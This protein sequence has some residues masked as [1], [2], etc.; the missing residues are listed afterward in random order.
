MEKYIQEDMVFSGKRIDFP[1]WKVKIISKAA[2]ATP[3]HNQGV[4]GIMLPIAHFDAMFPP[5]LGPPIVRQYRPLHDPQDFATW[6]AIA[7]NA[8]TLQFP[9]AIRLAQFEYATK[10]Y[11]AVQ[12]AANT[13]HSFI[14][15]HLDTTTKVTISHPQTGVA[16]LDLEQLFTAVNNIHGV[17]TSADLGEVDAK[18]CAKYDPAL[19]NMREHIN[20]HANGHLL[21]ESAGSPISIFNKTKTFISS[22]SHQPSY[23]TRIKV[24]MEQTPQVL[25]QTFAALSL[26]MIE[27]EQVAKCFA[28]APTTADVNYAGGAAK[29]KGKGK[30]GGHNSG[31][32]STPAKRATPLPD[33]YCWSH[34]LCKHNSVHCRDKNDGH[35][36]SATLENPLGGATGHWADIKFTKRA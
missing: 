17:L 35:Q 16:H 27:F 24:W 30:D 12:Q 5:A 10:Q 25:N 29:K 14:F 6:I 31:H 34:G 33:M 36:D 26:V 8:P 4:L 19:T 21:Y 18:M 22:F 11:Q 3:L 23:E 1:Q 2:N 32:S 15:S 7:A 28:P 20:T 13:M 9:V